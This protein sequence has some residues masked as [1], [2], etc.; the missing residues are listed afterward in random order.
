MQ[1]QKPISCIILVLNEPIITDEDGRIVK[2][3]L[4]LENK[5]RSID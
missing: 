1:D 4:H 3:D 2:L 5:S